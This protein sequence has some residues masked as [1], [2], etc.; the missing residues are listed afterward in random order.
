MTTVTHPMGRCECGYPVNCAT[1]ATNHAQIAPKPGDVSVC[2]CCSR[3]LVYDQSG[4]PHG[5]SPEELLTLDPELHRDL[6]E[7]QVVLRRAWSHIERRDALLLER[8]S[9]QERPGVRARLARQLLE[10]WAA[11]TVWPPRESR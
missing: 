7:A 5:I 2:G 10:E 8:T 1:R 11:A 3:V 9:P 6:V 4:V